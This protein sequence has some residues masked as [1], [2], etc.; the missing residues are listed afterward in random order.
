MTDFGGLT[1]AL[2]QPNQ[3]L[4]S[5]RR[6]MAAFSL[7]SLAT[8]AAVFLSV[9]TNKAIAVF[10]G[11]EGVALSGLYRGLG[12]FA[13]SAA[14]CGSTTIVLQRVAA[15]R[16]RRESSE[17]ISAALLLL[18]LQAILIAVFALAAPDLI[19]AWL[20]GPPASAA[21]RIEIQVV[22][23][24]AFFNLA[25][26][27][28]TAMIKGQPDMRPV[29]ALMIATSA[30]SLAVIYPLLMHGR[31]GLAVS[32]G[33][34][35]V[36][37]SIVGAFFV[38]RIFRPS[39]LGD[40]FSAI[41]K[42]LSEFGTASL[43][44]I[45]QSLGMAGGALIVQGMI[46]RHY[47]LGG[48]GQ[49]NAAMLIRETTVMVLMGSARTYAL[50]VLGRLNENGRK[51]I[52]FSRTLRLLLAANCTAALALIFGSRLIL[53]LLFSKEFVP[54]SDMLTVFGFSL[55][56]LS[57]AWSYNTFLLHKGDIATFVVLDLL[58][59]TALIGSAW[60]G[61]R[62]GMPLVYFAWAYSLCYALCGAA[63]AAVVRWKYGG[64]YLTP[65]DASLGVL[66]L[67]VLAAACAVSRLDMPYANSVFLGLCVAGVLVSLGRRPAAGWLGGA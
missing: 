43:W 29:A 8:L 22:L 66:S 34:G 41:Q 46:N 47:G 48:L 1:E 50:P 19:A 40:G 23:A 20:F 25:L 61:V 10:A 3:D 27:T 6:I 16:S 51:E 9:L 14:T 37:G 21:L 7:M 12:A 30:G 17:V 58:C 57:F 67:G 53:R 35:G 49:Y 39:I 38:L 54:A 36:L 5:T 59:M 60:L 4:T 11:A 52:F 26:Q 64:G 45:A 28:V 15:T 55:I 62:L 33:S 18:A 32:V 42:H 56:G 13:L 31:L 24:M 44:L 63:Y 2:R 65:S